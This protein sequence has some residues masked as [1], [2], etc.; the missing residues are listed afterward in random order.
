MKSNYNMFYQQ[1]QAQLM[2]ANKTDVDLSIIEY[3]IIV[4]TTLM[5]IV[6]NAL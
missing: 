3:I 6:I 2:N 4:T 1:C 5:L